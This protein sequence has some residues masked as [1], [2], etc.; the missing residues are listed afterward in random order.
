VLILVDC[1]LYLTVSD[2][3]VGD[4]SGGICPLLAMTESIHF[5]TVMISEHLS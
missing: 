1:F 4:C 3:L 2:Y 5:S